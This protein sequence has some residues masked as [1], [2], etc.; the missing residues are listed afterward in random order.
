M[1]EEGG[2]EPYGGGRRWEPIGGESDGT[3]KRKRKG[4]TLQVIPI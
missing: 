1:E 4:G 3:K 2:G